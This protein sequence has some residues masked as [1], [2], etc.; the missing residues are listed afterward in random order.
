ML[1]PTPSFPFLARSSS[2][3]IQQNEPAE[4]LQS[5]AGSMQ[6]AFDVSVIGLSASAASA[7]HC[8]MVQD[9]PAEALQ[10]IAGIVLAILVDRKKAVPEALLKAAAVL[11]DAALLV[12]PHF[13][14]VG[15]AGYD[16]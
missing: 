11:H 10:S 12:R 9:E 1:K 3:L 16:T 7:R 15:R 6:A 4:A 13:T 8:S 5:I 2:R 14:C